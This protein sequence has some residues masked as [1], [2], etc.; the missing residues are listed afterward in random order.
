M[1]PEGKV[2]EWFKTQFD[3]RYGHL[4]TWW[5]APPGGRFGQ[6][7]TGD[8][9]FMVESVAVMVEVKKDGGEATALQ[10]KR[11]RDFAAAGG[12]AGVLVGKDMAKVIAIFAEIDRR[13]ELFRM[14]LKEA[15][16]GN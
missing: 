3:R 10:M 6:A 16:N 14:A 12:V 5:Y 4:V 7:G 13:R 8:R 9:V 1:T 2:K 11:L 15:E